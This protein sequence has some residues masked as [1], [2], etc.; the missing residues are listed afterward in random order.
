MVASEPNGNDLMN[1]NTTPQAADRRHIDWVYATCQESS[2]LD[3][4][5]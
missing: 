1:D 3:L 5:Q 4:A 2:C